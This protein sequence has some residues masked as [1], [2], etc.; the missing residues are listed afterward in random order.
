MHKQRSLH[1]RGEENG[2]ISKKIF[3]ITLHMPHHDSD[4][5]SL[6]IRMIEKERIE[7]CMHIV[8]I[9]TYSTWR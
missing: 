2:Q 9:Y 4:S 3:N 5:T 6:K 7:N 1:T 8:G